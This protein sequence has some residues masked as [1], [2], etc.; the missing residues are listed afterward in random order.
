MATLD[1]S[2]QLTKTMVIS[3]RISM[4]AVL[5]TASG[6]SNSLVPAYAVTIHFKARVRNI[7]RW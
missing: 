3:R 7:R 4:V 1:M 5:F 2:K 6:N